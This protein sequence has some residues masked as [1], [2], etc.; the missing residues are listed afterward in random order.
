[1]KLPSIRRITYDALKTARRFP[2]PLLSALA[3]TVALVTIIDHEASAQPTFLWGALLS[4]VLGIPLL[5]ASTL[6]TERLAGRKLAGLLLQALA[7]IVVVA[8]ALAVPTELTNAPGMHVVRWLLLL[9]TAHMLV[10]IVPN[11][12]GDNVIAFWQYNKTLF[13]RIL[14]TGLFAAIVFAGLAFAL[15]ALNNLFDM[16][17]AGKRYGQLWAVVAGIF[18]TW[19]FLA[20]VPESTDKP[21]DLAEYPRGMKM[22]ALYILLPIVLVYLGILYAYMAKIL[23]SWD[24]PQGWVSKLI[25]G[26]SGAGILSLLL[27]YPLD[28]D[29][30]QPWIRKLRRWFYLSLAPLVIMLFLAVSRRVGEYGMTE[31]RYAAIGLGVWLAIAI[32][33]FLILPG[34][35]IKFIPVSLCIGALLMSFG[36]WGMFHIAEQSQT[37]RLETLLSK[38]S[39]L[40]D[41]KVRPVRGNLPRKDTREI[42]AILGYLHDMHGYESIQPW[43][44][45][46]LREDT[47]KAG[48]RYTGPTAVA[49]KMGVHY[50]LVH[51][52]PGSMISLSVERDTT[53]DVHGFDGLVRLL[54]ISVDQA[55]QRRQFGR[56]GIRASKDLDSLVVSTVVG[57][58]TGDSVW[59]DI[60]KLLDGVMAAHD[61]LG[62]SNLSPMEM[63]IVAE[64]SA[65]RIRLY[66]LDAMLEKGEERIRILNYSGY[67]LYAAAVKKESSPAAIQPA[68]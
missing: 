45:E 31:G 54:R 5:I 8:F 23:I 48:V 35:N 10:A 1:M 39:I 16:H 28:R 53:Y 9:F 15:A 3:A 24:W 6:L 56:I 25:L 11:A 38:N 44:D 36:P 7:L 13:I 52:E 22:F 64:S 34:K 2:L 21:G 50:T 60:R 4:G 32:I 14:I 49:E 41:G 26:F 40:V 18:T 67:V 12:S 58:S 62:V 51:Q 65:L 55:D 66:I 33:Y 46:I 59:L 27:L 61:S 29:T 68:E 19:S 47:A 63:T 57:G 37:T 20:G 17:V 42:S 43:F 30:E